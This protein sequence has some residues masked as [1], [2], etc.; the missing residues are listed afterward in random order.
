MERIRRRTPC[1]NPF[2]F[3]VFSIAFLS[4]IVPLADGMPASAA[5]LDRVRES[6]KITF[7]YRTDARPFSYQ[8]DSGKAAGYSVALCEKVAEAVKGELDLSTL[9]TEWIPLTIEERIQAVQQGKVDLF[10][11]AD[12]ATLARRKEV[13]IFDPHLPWWSRCGS[14]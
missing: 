1:R 5:T 8:D 6:A 12:T 10:C 13:C 4:L 14:A 11:G 2:R 3:V 9:T 7:G